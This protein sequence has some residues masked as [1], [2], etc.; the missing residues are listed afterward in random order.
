MKVK[1]KV[2]EMGDNI[3]ITECT[4]KKHIKDFL[5]FPKYIY[6]DEYCPQDYKTEKQLLTGKHVL[7][8]DF[9]ITPMI[10]YQVSCD[11]YR[12]LARCI[13]TE[14]EN[15]DK[16]YI[17]LF[18]SIDN[19]YVYTKF[20]LEVERK[21]KS[22]GKKQMVGPV[23]A[24]FWI[25]YRFK[26]SS[27]RRFRDT[28]TGEPYNKQTYIRMWKDAGFEVDNVYSSNFYRQVEETDSSEKCK[29][30]I[31]QMTEKGYIIKNS[32]FKSFDK[33]I[34]EIYRMITTLY[35]NFP[36]YKNL[37]F[38]QFKKL[39][40][41]LKWVLNYSMVKMVYKDGK[42]V[43]FFICVPNYTEIY[44]ENNLIF[45]LVNL[46]RI[47]RKPK[48]YVML[49]MGVEGKHLGLGGALAEVT[50]QELFKNKC[51]SIGALIQEGKAT[52]IYYKN[53]IVGKATYV[54]LKKNIE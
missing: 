40:G 12:V 5:D 3:H 16:A 31:R 32:S 34:H 25:R 53:L 44:K 23:D 45:I 35:S 2:V 1:V 52:N 38:E 54:T 15:D 51:T 7:S 42:A 37:T 8:K 14:Y 26:Q 19:Y 47:R 28:Y 20:L 22:L 6:S 48:E 39:F 11:N 21:C 4:T 46:L 41:Y 27:D 29:L 30:R 17:G 49:Y 50:K 24:S 43:A 18:E 10:A 9:K 36:M 33:D 13:I